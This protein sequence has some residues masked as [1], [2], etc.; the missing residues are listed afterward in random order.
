MTLRFLGEQDKS[1]VDRI[2]E[3]LGSY[4][5]VRNIGLY[6]SSVGGFPDLR[7]PR[8]IFVGIEENSKL[9]QLK[10]EVD[11]CLEDIGISSDDREYV[12]HLTIGRVKKRVKIP[13]RLPE[14]EPVAFNINDVTI[15]RSELNRSGSVHIPVKNFKI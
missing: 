10:R 1:R 11:R 7:R 15:F 4:L 14:I 9:T 12:P 2:S 5:S 8:V 13:D 3:S 6:L